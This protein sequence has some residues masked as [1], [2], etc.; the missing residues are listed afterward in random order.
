MIRI[1]INLAIFGS[2]SKTIKA[3]ISKVLTTHQNT[4][5]TRNRVPDL[6]WS[7]SLLNVH[8]WCV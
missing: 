5:F 2:K 4:K 7:C 6:A 8:L 1:G 3:L